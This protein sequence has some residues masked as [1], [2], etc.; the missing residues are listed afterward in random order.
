MSNIVKGGRA[1]IYIFPCG[2]INLIAVGD[3]KVP[4]DGSYGTVVSRQSDTDEG[5]LI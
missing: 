4:D 1:I 5:L 3:Y 2:T